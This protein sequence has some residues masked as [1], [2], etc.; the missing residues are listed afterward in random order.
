MRINGAVAVV[1]GAGGG[2]GAAI[3]RALVDGG[4]RVV[5]T[6]INGDAVA[7]VA[8]DLPPDAVAL[9]SGDAG[10]DEHIDEVVALAENTFGPVDFYFAN[11]GIMGAPGLHATDAQ[12]DAALNV[13]VLAHVRAARRLVPGWVERGSGYFIS[14]ASAAGLLTQLGSATYSV[15]KHAAVGFAEWL[16]VTYGAQGVKVSCLCPMGV[17]TALLRPSEA[18]TDAEQALMQRAVTTAGR[19]LTA[20]E[21]AAVVLAAIVEEHFLIL[22]HAEVLDM[23]RHKGSDYDRWLRGMQRYL[24]ALTS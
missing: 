4:A 22:P 6:D 10:A 5:L 9:A 3:A 13:N 21:V 2:I 24:S 11:A 14:T 16:S 20:D 17:D 23:Y 8:A 15:T 1:T 18:P 12:W 7:R 19:V